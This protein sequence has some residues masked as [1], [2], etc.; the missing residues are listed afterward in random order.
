MKKEL[1]TL[2]LAVAMSIVG[3]EA[4]IQQVTYS[5]SAVNAQKHELVDIT[6]KASGSINAPFEVD[7]NANFTSPSGATQSIP[8]FY[9]GDKEWV[10][11]F[12]ATEAGEWSYTTDSDLKSLNNKSGRV[13]VSSECYADRRG[14]VKIDPN[15]KRH[16]VWGDG[17]PYLML[18]FECDFLFALDYGLD[19]RPRM[20]HFVDKLEEYNFNHIIMNVYANDVVWAKDEKLRAEYEFG[21]SD[22]MFPFLGSNTDPDYSAL[23]VEFFKSL[24]ETMEALN[25]RNLVSHLMI[26]VWNKAV[27]WPDVESAEDDRYF[28]YV[29][30]RYQSFTNL[31]WDISKE[32]LFYGKVDDGFVS[33]RIERLRELDSYK[34]L[35]TVHDIGYCNRHMDMVDMASNQDWKLSIYAQMAENYKDYENK[36]VLNIEYGGYE[37]SDYVVF[38]GNYINAEECLRRNYECLFAG[39]YTT[40]YWQGC[41]WNVLIYDW[42][43]SSNVEYRPKMHYF[44]YLGDFFTKYPFHTFRPL[45]ER[46]NSG[47]CMVNEAEDTY[48]IYMPCESYKMAMGKF[49]KSKRYSYQWFNTITGE[50]TDIQSSA[51]SH[52]WHTQDDAI[53]IIKVLD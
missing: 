31:V 45:P 3:V 27:N 39:T 25:D 37:Q 30:K 2:F 35:V 40:Y 12:S 5:K 18:G 48:I 50:Y 44:E 42:D 19:Q 47:F 49:D 52:P 9:N 34:R 28:D 21:G 17:S 23:N 15:D 6:F 1:L 38:T 20:E 46:N 29:V 24:D 41:S 32:A 51:G 43:T 33:R 8:A 36:P 11:R 13:V 4:A 53:M 16:L 7:F 22:E 14:A 10:V 26:Y